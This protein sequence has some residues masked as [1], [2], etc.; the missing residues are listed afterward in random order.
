VHEADDVV[1]VG[2]IDRP[3]SPGWYRRSV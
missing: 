1:E 3:A 2:A